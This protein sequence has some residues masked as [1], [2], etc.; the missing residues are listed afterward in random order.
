MGAEL[1]DSNK[2][3]Q[4]C[5]MASCKNNVYRLRP[6]DERSR[7]SHSRIRD[8]AILSARKVDVDAPTTFGRVVGGQ[9]A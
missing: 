4:V 5:L 6:R 1:G 9:P 2:V 3:L 7:K 8:K